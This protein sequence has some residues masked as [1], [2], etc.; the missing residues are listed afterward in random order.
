MLDPARLKLR[1]DT[2]HLGSLEDR[3]GD[4]SKEVYDV[5]ALACP[6][7]GRL[8]FVEVVTGSR[9]GAAWVTAPQL[10]TDPP[11]VQ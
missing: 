10:M 3:L 6:C 9:A 8:K 7:G 11:P 5:D 4:P 2:L 1:R